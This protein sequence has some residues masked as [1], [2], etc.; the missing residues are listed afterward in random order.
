MVWL[1]LYAT[2]AH[3]GVSISVPEG[4]GRNVLKRW[5]NQEII[6]LLDYGGIN[7]F[8]IVLGQMQ[9]T[10]RVRRCLI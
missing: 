6:G 1:A 4:R 2:M 10:I 8:A 5:A 3:S 9:R 7:G